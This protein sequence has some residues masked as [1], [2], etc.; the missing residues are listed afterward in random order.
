MRLSRDQLDLLEYTWQRRRQRNRLVLLVKDATTVFA[1]W[2]IADVQ[3]NLL[4]EHFSR[5]WSD[6][7]LF[8][9]L[10]DV[11]DLLF[12]GYHANETRSESVHPESDHWFFS[13]VSPTRHYLADICTQTPEG[14]LFAILQSNVIQTPPS[15][16][17]LIEHPSVCFE[18]LRQEYD[19]A[20]SSQSSRFH[21]QSKVRLTAPFDRLFNGYTWTDQ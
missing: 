17:L 5:S 20:Q 14:G 3:R 15:F 18:P 21:E 9:R 19:F 1:Y 7:P 8:L 2:E 4:C 13:N 10:H 16:A 6:F 12:D 11:T